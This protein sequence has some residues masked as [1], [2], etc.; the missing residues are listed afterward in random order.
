MRK[1]VV[2]I[3]GAYRNGSHQGI[4][5]NIQHARR[6][7]IKLWQQGYVVLCPHLNTA[8]F[9][10]LCS[11]GVWLD[12]DIELMIRCDA[13]YFLNNWQQ[14]VGAKQEYEIAKERGLELLF[15]ASD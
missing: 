3:S 12:G 15:E 7:A 13:V 11:D 1:K 8:H 4:E 2:F 5:D 9:D 14:S 6:E 10:G